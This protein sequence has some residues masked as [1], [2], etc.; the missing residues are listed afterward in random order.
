MNGNN[1]V[2]YKDSQRRKDYMKRY[3][4]EYREK[5]PDYWKNWKATDPEKRKEYVKKS[6]QKHRTAR[7]AKCKSWRMANIGYDLI[8]K[9]RRRCEIKD[10]PFDL[11]RDWVEARFTG[12]C[13]LSEQLFEFDSPRNPFACSLD[14]INSAQG[15][16]KNNCRFI[17]LGLNMLKGT[18]TDWDMFKIADALIQTADERKLR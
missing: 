8:L 11:D 5:N 13:E 18:G 1:V 12:Y 3:N 7:I 15:Y 14:R 17:L 2:P 6:Y 10:I 16:T 4:K 9:A